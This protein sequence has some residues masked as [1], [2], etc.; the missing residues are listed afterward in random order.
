MVAAAKQATRHRPARSSCARLAFSM[1]YRTYA[2][3]YNLSVQVLLSFLPFSARGLPGCFH[4]HGISQQNLWLVPCTALIWHRNAPPTQLRSRAV[5]L[6][7]QKLHRCS[8]VRFLHDAFLDQQAIHSCRRR[9]CSL[10]GGAD[11]QPAPIYTHPCSK[12][13]CTLL[14]L[15]AH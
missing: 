15:R 13:S 4:K 8:R 6:R 7:S 1:R 11:S 2:P 9:A 12:I 3:S 5:R 14:R 10:I